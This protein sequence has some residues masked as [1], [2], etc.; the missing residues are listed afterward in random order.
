LLAP[1][2]ATVAAIPWGFAGAGV[3]LFSPTG[4]VKGRFFDASV[5]SADPLAWSPD[6]R[7]LAVAL[8]YTNPAKQNRSGLAVIDTVTGR[9][10]MLARGGIAGA[11]F[12]P[13]GPDRLV[14]GRGASAD[15]RQPV[16][17]F[18]AAATGGSI[19]QLTHDA[20][21]SDPVWGARGI[22]FNHAPRPNPGTSINQVW[23]IQP[24]GTHRTQIT[25]FKRRSLVYG[26]T[27]LQFS[28]NGERLLAVY[29]GGSGTSAQ[30]WAIDIVTRRAR[31]LRI[32]GH[33]VTPGGLSQ[34]GKVVLVELDRS[35]AP[36]GTIE[37]IGFTGTK[38]TVLARGL[39][40]TWNR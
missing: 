2:G 19:R 3:T 25:D 7:Y 13:N 12:A 14:Y 31:K 38:P 9:T 4:A 32:D 10:V 37:T 35:A 39:S 15:F 26:L 6:S 11:S 40:P 34:D 20:W 17:L 5:V 29:E 27:P 28:S 30:T 8:A 1:D 16:N 18:I 36:L 22:A 21:S 33:D 24:D 23:L